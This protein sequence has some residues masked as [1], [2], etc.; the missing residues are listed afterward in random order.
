MRSI[1]KFPIP[2]PGESGAISVLLPR[3][4]RLLSVHAQ[5]EEPQIWALV[6]PAA[7]KV[8]RRLL[9]A[10]TGQTGPARVPETG[11]R[12]DDA[13]FVGTFL[14]LG[15]SLVFHV[16]DFGESPVPEPEDDA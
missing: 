14:L 16:F 4:A 1:W 7:P 8:R 11:E 10:V 12:F 9:I 2:S 5:R 13:K 6:D 3:G 15:G